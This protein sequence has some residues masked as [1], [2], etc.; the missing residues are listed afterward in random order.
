MDILELQIHT[1]EE[2][3]GFHIQHETFDVNDL[4]DVI[5]A[6][7]IAEAKLLLDEINTYINDKIE[8]LREDSDEDD[9]D[10]E[11]C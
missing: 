6:D 8:E 11:M 9:C 5:L 1:E 4:K 7:M 2:G 3:I 10:C